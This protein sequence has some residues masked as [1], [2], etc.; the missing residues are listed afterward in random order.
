MDVP[1]NMLR[2]KLRRSVVLAIST[3]CVVSQ[4]S[5]PGAVSAADP[6]RG[7]DAPLAQWRFDGADTLGSWQG[8]G[9]KEGP[10]PR[11]PGY[12]NFS[13]EN[14][15]AE[16]AGKDAALV[17]TDPGTDGPE[18]LRFHKGDSIT[19]EAWVKVRSLKSGQQVYLVGKG[20]NGTK[21]FGG[22][23][24]NYA[25]RLKGGKGTASIGFLFTAQAENGKPVTW[26]RW[27][28]NDE[29]Q[30]DAGWHHVALTYTFG[31]AD[32]LRGFIDGSEVKGLWD[33]DGATDRAPVSD[34]DALVIGTG[35]GRGANETLDGWLEDV[36]IY[37]NALDAGTLKARY[38]YVPPAPPVER[39]QLT[40]GRVLVQL[41]EKGVPE[42]P[43]WPAE[44]PLATE[45]YFEEVFGFFEVPHKYVAS[46][47][48]G[49]RANAFLLRASA[50][51]NLPK[52]K[53][54][55]LLR[56]RGSSR[57][58]IDGK[59][60]LK[61]KFPQRDTGGF[62]L[63]EEQKEYLNLG[64]D[65]RFAPPGNK[66]EWCEFESAGG[67]H[68]VVM[69]TIVGGGSGGGR[70]RPELGETVVAISP[71]GSQSWS[72]LSPGSRKVAYTDEDWAAY[73]G[74]RTAHYAKVNA[75][76]RAEKRREHADYW[77][78]RRKAAQDWLASTSEVPVP[79][80]PAGY[81]G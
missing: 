70:F 52:G 71:E 6:A 77:A 56:G 30:V 15:A 22:L 31:K 80:L 2:G 40:P 21:E 38:A 17:V 60:L 64:P 76:A 39:N 36:A 14:R 11:A 20:R 66:E 74:E 50:V 78:G 43:M 48:R 8:K 37:R 28:S 42:K 27:W 65:F 63:I 81:P 75:K 62:G 5:A 12:T 29:F 69:E 3:V 68:L 46:G 1:L 61:T 10:G 7:K 44:P 41:C 34:G 35:F 33:L 26:H 32:S 58:Y 25:L 24:Q 47:V 49:D 23:N 55:L 79:A 18:G 45:S 59:E 4:L 54:R 16:L 67:E 13:M 73:E 57:L 9:Y 19:I 53:H 72:L 51:V